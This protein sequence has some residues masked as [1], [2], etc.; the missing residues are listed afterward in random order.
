MKDVPIILSKL[1]V[2]RTAD[3]IIRDK[4]KP[5]LLEIPVKKITNVTVGAGYGKTTLIAQAVKGCE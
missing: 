2:P 3:T 1:M 5:L 4:L